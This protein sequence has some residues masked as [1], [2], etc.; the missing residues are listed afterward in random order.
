[1]K[2]KNFAYSFIL[3]A[4]ACSRG[5]SYDSIKLFDPIKSEDLNKPVAAAAS[6]TRLYALDSKKN[7]LFIFD[8][9]GKP[10]KAVT[11]DPKHPFKRPRGVAL[12]ADG[13][14][15][16]ADTG[17]SRVQILSADGQFLG[18]FGEN[19]SQAGELDSPESVAVGLDGRIYVADTGNNRVQ[20]FTEEGILLFQ[21]GEKGSEPGKFKSPKK[22]VVDPSDEI[23][24]FDYGNSRIE[25]FDASARFAREF[26]ATGDFAVD[27]FGFLYAL[28]GKKVAEINPGGAVLGRFGSE[29]TGPGQLKKSEGL[30]VAADGTILVCDTGNG[31]IQRIEL[32]S[33]EKTTLLPMNVATKI[34]VSGPSRS[35]DYAA[36]GIA[37]DGQTLY[38]WI[39]KDKQFALIDENG[40]EKSRI[41]A[42][43][44]AEAPS[45]TTG[46]NGFAVSQKLGLFVADS[47]NVR[48]QK[49]TAD[50]SWKTNFA[51]SGGFMTNKTKEG[52]I[53]DPRGVAINDAG[54]VYLAD[55]GNKRVDAFNP[56]G[57]FLF[58][59]G[60]SVGPVQLLEPT[61]LAWDKARFL[62]IIDKKLRKVVKTE[63]S[64]AYLASWG[65]QGSGPGQ[66][67]EPIAA[68]YDGNTYLYVLDGA[69][70]RVSVFAK[71]GR[72]MTDLFSGGKDDHALVDPVGLALQ[73][74]RLLIA[75][76]GRSKILSF[77]LRFHLAAPM[78]LAVQMKDGAVA[79]S[80][81][82]VADSWVDGYTVLRASQPAGPYEDIGKADSARFEDSTAAAYA[83]YWY[84]A[85]T[86]SKTGDVGVAASPVE[87]AVGGVFNKPPVELSTITI[88][89]IF[90]ANYKW[91]LKNP[92][93]MAVVT[94]N[95]QAPFE[96]IKI[97]FRLKDFMDFGYDQEIKRLA[98]QQTV[99]LPLIATLN[100]KILE[101]TEDTPIQAEFTLTYF[102]GGQ[103][104]SLSMTKPLR[105]YSRNAIVWNDP[106]R[107]A[108]FITP[109]DPPVL[110]FARSAVRE[111]PKA[112]K[113][114][115]LNENVVT[116]MHIWDSLSEYGVSF[117]SN[118]NN[119]YEKLSEDPNF[120]VDYTQ[121][122]RETLKRKSGQCDDLTTLIIA[123]LDGT[124]V[125]AAVV[126]YPGHMALMFDTE[127]DDVFE[128]GFP[129]S[130]MIKRNGTW[131]VPLEA[132]MIGKPFQ[133]AVSKAANAYYTEHARG[134]VSVLDVADAWRQY[135]PATMSASD[136]SPE[137]PKP[138]MRRARFEAEVA[139][140]AAQRY[141]ALK[142][143]YDY[144]VK[145][146]PDVTDALIDLG[147]LEETDG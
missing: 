50:G 38:A 65:E 126:D 39:A 133:E 27:G 36:E 59:I 103:Q 28:D 37:A 1:M 116:A 24:V 40:K 56:D 131:W 35:W 108:N 93:G 68:V 113:E 54:T 46:T 138:A 109:K 110:E 92:I 21:F 94:N 99:E 45:A 90:S 31:R 11:G 4:V 33:K 81:K 112:P 70:K 12:G 41:G 34:L 114:D 6:L 13:K 145:N 87:F 100:N 120:P 125:P 18:A 129:E 130:Q 51:E 86:R 84:R 20:V 119:P 79:L 105:V 73:G 23:Y 8:L 42:K 95:V 96:N 142:R 115:S 98:P 144:R 22:V 5:E 88:G 3:L 83:K 74:S 106:M 76:K 47:Q 55:T 146:G 127:T 136:W 104:R 89:N 77:D 10:L 75:D 32:T 61:A 43:G 117:F 143:T 69:L 128:A 64:G 66:F 91:Y 2:I 101:V 15:F 78:G 49:F 63:P 134:K 17:N 97:S 30:A 9:A 102:E 52:R 53:K 124:K 29:G 67:Q 118:P 135:E 140:L 25:K 19:G 7:Q 44:G 132:T 82:P 147:L 85:A 26:P 60:P 57:V 139:A 72:W 141:E 137:P 71:D 58:G 107:I 14:I 122:P 16:I 123:M 80:W 121:F 48:M 111:A 62:Y